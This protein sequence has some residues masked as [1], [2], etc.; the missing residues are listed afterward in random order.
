MAYGANLV[1]LQEIKR[2]Y[3]PQQRFKANGPIL[4]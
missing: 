2:K 3:D 4:L 1:K